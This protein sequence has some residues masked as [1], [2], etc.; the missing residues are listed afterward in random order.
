MDLKLPLSAPLVAEYE[1]VVKR[2][3]SCTK[4]LLQQLEKQP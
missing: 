3:T 4:A 1:V 2:E